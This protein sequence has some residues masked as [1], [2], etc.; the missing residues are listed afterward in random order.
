MPAH[1]AGRMGGSAFATKKSAAAAAH[2]NHKEKTA[3]EV[4]HVPMPITTHHFIYSSPSI[5]A[6]VFP[7]YSPSPSVVFDISLVAAFIAIQIL[8]FAIVNRRD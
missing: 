7:F 3:T 1:S 8:F 4:H 6:P 5:T 2:T